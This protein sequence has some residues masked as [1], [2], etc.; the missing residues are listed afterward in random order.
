[1]WTNFLS[2]KE[3]SLME[4]LFSAIFVRNYTDDG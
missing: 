1:M 4:S 2:K 3:Q